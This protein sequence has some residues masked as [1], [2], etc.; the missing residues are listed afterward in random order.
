MVDLSLSWLLHH[1][2]TACIVLGASKEEQ[3]TENLDAFE[4]GPLSEDV[5]AACGR[6]WQK[7]RG[8]TPKY[9]R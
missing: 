6:V 2:A 5:L 9:N 4:R 3:L 8:I 7:L 1:T